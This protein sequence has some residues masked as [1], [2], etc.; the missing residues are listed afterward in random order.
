[1]EFRAAGSLRASLNAIPTA[2]AE[3]SKLRGL[4]NIVGDSTSHHEASQHHSY[5]ASFTPAMRL[6]RCA[7][8]LWLVGMVHSKQ[9]Q[10]TCPRSGLFAASS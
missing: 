8:Q 4:V 6:D 10:G 5:G 9:A 1:M 2:E 7:V 3:A